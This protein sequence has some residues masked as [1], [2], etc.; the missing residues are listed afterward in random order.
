MNLND[1]LNV[2]IY[3]PPAASVCFGKT[4]YLTMGSLLTAPVHM[5][6]I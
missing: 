2:C 6:Y 5:F 1:H 3:F 4:V